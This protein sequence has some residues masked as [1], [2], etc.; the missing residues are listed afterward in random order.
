MSPALRRAVLCC[1]R[2]EYWRAG[3]VIGGFAACRLHKQIPQSAEH[4]VLA[5][6]LNGEAEKDPNNILKCPFVRGRDLNP[7]PPD[8]NHVF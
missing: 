7:E 1:R 3:D 6:H 8:Y 4:H 2:T 5:Q